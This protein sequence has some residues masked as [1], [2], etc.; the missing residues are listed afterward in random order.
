MLLSLVCLMSPLGIKADSIHRM[1]G[2]CRILPA[3]ATPVG[4]SRIYFK[5]A[6]NHWGAASQGPNVMVK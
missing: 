3:F 2:E 1:S 6:L 4:L 5:K